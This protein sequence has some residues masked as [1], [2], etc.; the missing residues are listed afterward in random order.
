MT[1]GRRIALFDRR[2]R[3]G[4]EAFEQS[5]DRFVKKIVLDGDRGLTRQ[6]AHDVGGVFVKGDDVV[7]NA[8]G[9]EAL[10]DA[11]APAVDELQ[12]A[13]RF[14]HV[15]GH[16]KHEQRLGEIS[17]LLVER[18][19]DLVLRAF[20]KV[21]GVV[22]AEHLSGHRDVT[23]E[24]LSRN[25]QDALFERLHVDGIVLRELPAEHFSSA[26]LFEQVERSGVGA[27]KLPRLAE[28]HRQQDGVIADR[29]ERRA[30]LGDLLE[31]ARPFAE[32]LLEMIG[33]LF[34]I[35]KLK[36]ALD[37]AEECRRGRIFL[38]IEVNV[39][40]GEPARLL[41]EADADHRRARVERDRAAVAFKNRRID[42]HDAQPAG[43]TDQKLIECAQATRCDRL[44][45]EGV[46]IAPDRENIRVQ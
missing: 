46:G 33:A 17:V 36:R 38:Q 10:R 9:L 25:R 34:L 30:D 3:R 32:L 5:L 14:A 19:I 39:F 4:D 8:L 28:D 40:I 22:D 23:G 27:R 12:H 37:R 21:V 24:A 35:E 2:D 13:N 11:G 7:G 1:G 43:V 26:E 31:L 45:R 41:R 6:R 18:T 29:R 15:I 42:E 16:R 20:G 44:S